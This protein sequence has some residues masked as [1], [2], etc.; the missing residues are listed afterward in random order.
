[1]AAVF[2]CYLKQEPNCESAEHLIRKEVAHETEKAIC[3]DLLRLQ[4]NYAAAK[5]VLC[6][7]RHW[8]FTRHALEFPIIEINSIQ[9]LVLMRRGR[10]NKNKKPNT[11]NSLLLLLIT[12]AAINNSPT[13]DSDV[14]SHQNS[15]RESKSNLPDRHKSKQHQRSLLLFP[16]HRASLGADITKQQTKVQPSDRFSDNIFNSLSAVAYFATFVESQSHSS[17]STCKHF[18]ANENLLRYNTLVR[19]P[20]RLSVGPEGLRWIRIRSHVHVGIRIY[21]PRN[22]VVASTASATPAAAVARLTFASVSSPA[23]ENRIWH[24]KHRS[25]LHAK[26][27]QQNR[28]HI[29]LHFYFSKHEN[30]RRKIKLIQE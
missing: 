4:Q 24:R 13:F 19:L 27:R 1:M 21:N 20:L 29:Y 9:T 2:Q 14:L 23:E 26:H 25:Q 17:K 7:T 10:N 15:A 16:A 12:V 22:V 8:D 28:Q 11:R 3:R 6:S 18:I 5:I 30:S